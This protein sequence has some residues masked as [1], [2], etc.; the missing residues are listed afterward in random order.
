MK[1]K[2]IFIA[3]ILLISVSFFNFNKASAAPLMSWPTESQRI[4]SDYGMRTIN[5]VTAFH[6]GIDIGG[7]TAGVSGDKVM[8]AQ[9]GVVQSAYYHSSVG[10]YGWVIF[11]NHTGSY[12]ISSSDVQTRYAHLKSNIAV[13]PGQIVSRGTKIGEMG[14][15]GNPGANGSYGVHLHFETRYCST[16]TC[17]SSSA[18][19]PLSFLNDYGGG[20]QP[21]FYNIINFEDTSSNL[22]VEG[23]N[24]FTYNEIKNMT[25]EERIEIG[26]PDPYQIFE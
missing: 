3:V 21:L 15:S 16:S 14:N 8:A 22:D 12:R 7:K 11:I 2:S 20:P 6:Y 4:T 23:E 17:S 5:G 18:T 13:S 10:G 1:R 25:P 24:W 9:S 19:N 26:Y